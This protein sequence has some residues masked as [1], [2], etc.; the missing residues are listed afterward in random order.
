MYYIAI[1]VDRHEWRI[2]KH[3][4]T[5]EQAFTQLLKTRSKG[6]TAQAFKAVDGR[7]RKVLNL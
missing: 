2:I 5:S 7:F 6:L 4:S 1:Q 3:C